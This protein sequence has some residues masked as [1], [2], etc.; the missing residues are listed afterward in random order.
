M[1]P[2]RDTIRSRYFPIMTWLLLGL[3]TLVF[4]FELSLGPF[5]LDRFIG[6][7]G[8]VPARLQ[9]G[10]LLFLISLFT[11]MFMHSGWFHLLSNMWTLYIFGDNVEDR[12]GPLGFLA[13]YLLSGVAAGLLQTF[14]GLGSFIPILGASGAIAGVLGAYMLLYP[15]ARVLTIIPVFLLFTTIEVPAVFYLGFWFLSQLFSGF[16]SLGVAAGG[17]AWWA[18]IGG[19]LFGLF[20]GRLFLFRPPPPPPRPRYYPLPDEYDFG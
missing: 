18:H 14:A 2:L 13:F 11:S 16:G 6:V 5:E 8:I 17:V 12:M 3:N 15:R 7:F 10:Q 19:F 1:I 4:M 9:Q 20:L